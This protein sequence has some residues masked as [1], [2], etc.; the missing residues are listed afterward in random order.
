MTTERRIPPPPIHPLAALAVIALDN[1]FNVLEFLDP[2]LLLVTSLVVGL[3]G[4]LA[5][6]LSQ[7]FLAREG[8]GVAAAKGLV[9]GIIAGVPYS[10]TGTVVGAPLLLWAGVHQWANLL[11]ASGNNRLV[12]QALRPPELEDKGHK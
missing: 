9:M 10:V 1:V 6:L 5:T 12:D 8:W 3:L 7:R 2:F 11:P 4:F